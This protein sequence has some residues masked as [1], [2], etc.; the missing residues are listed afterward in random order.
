[1]RADAEGVSPSS[2]GVVDGPFLLGTSMEGVTQRTPPPPHAPDVH[3]LPGGFHQNEHV[4]FEGWTQ[5]F[6]G[7]TVM[8]GQELIIVGRTHTCRD[9][10]IN[11][12]LRDREGR[13]IEGEALRVKIKQLSRERP[14]ALPDGF[15]LG[16]TVYYTG[17][18]CAPLSRPACAHCR[19]LTP[20]MCCA[21]AGTCQ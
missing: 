17:P 19:G 14:F 13:P 12:F 7:C 4:Y 2:C 21:A 6:G 10:E 15:A 20:C 1:M 8:Y 3:P 9:G 18:V 11:V 5:T 16:E